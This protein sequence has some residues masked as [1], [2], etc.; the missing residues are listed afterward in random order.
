[1]LLDSNYACLVFPVCDD[2]CREAVMD[3][4]NGL[5]VCTVSGH[6]FDRLLS[7]A[8]MEPDIVSESPSLIIV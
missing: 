5:L 3:P 6:C 4:I 7:S 1:M 2:T 8:E